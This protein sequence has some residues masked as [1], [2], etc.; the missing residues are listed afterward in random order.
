[1]GIGITP[2]K[3]KGKCDV[4]KKKKDV[5]KIIETEK[6]KIFSICEECAEKSTLN[7]EEGMKKYGKSLG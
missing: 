7:L 5:R 1:M 3:E 4:C 6:K 2:N